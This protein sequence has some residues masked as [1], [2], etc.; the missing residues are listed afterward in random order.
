MKRASRKRYERIYTMR[1]KAGFPPVSNLKLTKDGEVVP[2][3]P[4]SGEPRR[5]RVTFAPSYYE[6]LKRVPEEDQAKLE[7]EVLKASE[8]LARNPY[9][10][11]KIDV[12]PLGWILNKLKWLRRELE[13]L[14]G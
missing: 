3:L 6:S 8:R 10:G 9:L 14:W 11:H 13:L 4:L 1:A 2:R 7:A 12:G 5:F